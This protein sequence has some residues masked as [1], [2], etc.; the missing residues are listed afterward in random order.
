MSCDALVFEYDCVVNPSTVT[1]RSTLP[2][3]DS[4]TSQMLW[5]SADMRAREMPSVDSPDAAV[6]HQTMSPS[7]SKMNGTFE[8]VPC[9]KDVMKNPLGT[10]AA[11]L[12]EK[13]VIGV[14]LSLAPVVTVWSL[15]MYV[16]APAVATIRKW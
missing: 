1:R 6:Y 12:T 8:P 2:D 14:E 5:L 16:F 4:L 9:Q 3:S 7:V 13:L 10:A 11:F 15:L